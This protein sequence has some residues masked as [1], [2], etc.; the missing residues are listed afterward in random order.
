MPPQGADPFSLDLVHVENIEIIKSAT[1]ATGPF[2]IAGTINIVRRKAEKKS[3]TQ[4]RADILTSGGKPGVDLSWSS[5]RAAE[6]S[7]LIYNL[8]LS[9]GRRNVPSQLDYAQILRQSVDQSETRLNGMR[10]GEDRLDTLILSSELAW[11]LNPDHKLSFSPDAGRVQSVSSSLERRQSDAAPTD[12]LEQRNR[13]PFNSYS[14]P[15]L[16]NWKI[17]AESRLKVRLNTGWNSI[18]ID[19]TLLD[20]RAGDSVRVVQKNEQREAHNHFLDVDYS[21]EYTG[22][23]EVAAGIKLAHNRRSTSYTDLVDG[24]P[25]ETLSSLGN[26]VATLSKRYQAFIQDDWRINRSWAAGAGLSMEYRTYALHEGPARDDSNFNIWSPTLHISHR[27]NGDRKHQLR[28]SL[29]RTFQAPSVEQMLLRPHINALAQCYEP[30]RCAAN[31]PETYDSAGNPRLRPERAL[32]FNLSYTHG[33]GKGSEAVLELYSRAIQ[34]KISRELILESVAWASAPRYVSRP[35]NI[36]SAKVFGV[37]LESRLSARDLWQ[38]APNVEV[39]GS[40]GFSHSEL[41]AIPAPD[42]RLPGQSPWRAKVALA[43]T[44][45][46]WPLKM[47]LDANWLPADWTRQS[48]A[49]R[50]YQGKKFTL[51]ANTSW[52]VAPGTRL[53]V[54]V[55][56]LFPQDLNRIDQYTGA[57]ESLLRHSSSSAFRRVVVGIDMSL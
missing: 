21:T 37:N 2:G 45:V 31:T 27:I 53:K 22:G 33:F 11:S 55:E 42:N 9:A 29:A 41:S 18:G 6:D 40:L 5:N 32:G 34:D 16:W 48:L 47:N 35:S 36:G 49:E 52:S 57:E 46:K 38:A 54:K 19:N 1:A 12:T 30:Q 23:H 4:L 15:V 44:S 14:L 3:T 7:P 56:N 28:M 43:Y 17:N 39:S 8:A 26:A 10:R 24:L 50:V 13:Q 25:D 51:N 20:A